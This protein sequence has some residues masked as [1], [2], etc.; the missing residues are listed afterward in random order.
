MRPW[1]APPC[2]VYVA[3]LAAP[4]DDPDQVQAATRTFAS[5]TLVLEVRLF[6]FWGVIRVFMYKP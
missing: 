5:G 2:Q 1:H 3:Q 4:L 6:K